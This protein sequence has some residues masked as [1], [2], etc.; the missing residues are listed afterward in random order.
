M[1]PL[2]RVR[3]WSELYENN[4]S[5]ELARTNWFPAPNDLSAGGYLDLVSHADGA[6][7]MRPLTQKPI[8]S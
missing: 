8:V 2:L 7:Q 3:N 6:A 4:R 1:P 5:R